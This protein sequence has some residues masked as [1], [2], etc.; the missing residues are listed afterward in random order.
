[1]VLPGVNDDATPKRVSCRRAGALS[2][3]MLVNDHGISKHSERWNSEPAT[4]RRRR[5]I[6]A[7]RGNENPTLNVQ[8]AR[9]TKVPHFSAR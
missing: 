6:P 3:R 1:M 2:R 4:T 8:L 5:L 9:L 7:G